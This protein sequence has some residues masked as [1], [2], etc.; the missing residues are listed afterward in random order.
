MT[1]DAPLSKN[2]QTALDFKSSA[3]NI[4]ALILHCNKIAD[5]KQQ[6]QLKISQAPDFFKNS[7]LLIDLH[8]LTQQQIEM[9]IRLL[10][11]TLR[12][13]HFLPVAIS[14][15]TDKQK[16]V[17]I[18]L[19]I[20][21]QSVHILSN[22]Q[23]QETVVPPPEKIAP[24]PEKSEPE[25]KP[26]PVIV[27]EAAP[28]VENKIITQPVRSGQRIYATGD[29]TVLAAVNPGAELMAEGN[30]HIYGPMRGRALAGVLGNT[31]SCIFCSD[32]QAEL[33]SIAGVYRLH[34]DLDKKLKQTL[35]HVYLHNQAL[36]VKKL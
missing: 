23:P 31:K 11:K 26:E 28:L 12:S 32:L 16:T 33:I 15:A 3:F 36:L 19:G 34:D 21:T 18:S 6:L 30:I 9:D 35:V 20:A 29:L 7:P 22:I 17:A 4:P 10:V 14:G 8:E 24:A 2:P 13:L 5:I 25:S 27:V 1:I